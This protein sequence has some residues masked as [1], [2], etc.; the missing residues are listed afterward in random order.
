MKVLV[1]GSSGTVGTHLCERLLEEG[2]EVVGADW[3]ENRWNS[4]VQK[5]TT[6]VDLRDKE[7]ALKVL[8]ADVDLV[9]HL[10]ANARVYDLVV[11]PQLAFDN[12]QTL[13]TL[14]EYARQKKVGKF[15]FS[16]S[17]EVYGNSEKAIHHE[18]E[19]LTKNC[20]S[21]YTASK[22]GGEAL[23]HA[24]QQCYGVDFVIFRYSNVYG[25]YDVSDRVIPIFIEKS[26]KGE[27]LTV[28]GKEK[29]LDFTYIEDAVNGTIGLMNAFDAVKGE[30]YNLATGYG[31]SLTDL[32][33]IVRE[34]VGSDNEVVIEESRTGE[35]IK[36]VA[37]ISKVKR[38]IEYDPKTTL[39]E[40][41]RSAVA[42][43]KENVKDK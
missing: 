5:I 41:V 22:I 12:F 19:A 30:V 37:D 11:D 9:I 8:P 3:K 34:V 23:I 13:F 35:V 18:D 4:E 29:F 20:E 27:D 24:Y 33:E 25:R 6:L 17:R 38:V 39:E 31:S 14:L 26:F 36:Y 43:Y 28:F 15:M 40:G 2:H 32:A 16:S 10:A 7:E 21:A 42:W 1:T